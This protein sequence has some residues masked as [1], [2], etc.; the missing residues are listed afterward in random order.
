MILDKKDEIRSQ[1]SSSQTVPIKSGRIHE[2]RS[3][4][5]DFKKELVT[6]LKK[7]VNIKNVGKNKDEKRKIK[8]KDFEG[9][10]AKYSSKTKN[11]IY[12]IKKIQR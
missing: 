7:I 12:K 2:E 4:N 5:K 11:L 1:I 6:N 10:S 9:Q 8:L 3:N